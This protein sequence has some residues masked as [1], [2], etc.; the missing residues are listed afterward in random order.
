MNLFL[1]IR[2]RQL[3]QGNKE[4]E[5]KLVPCES[6]KGVS[7]DQDSLFSRECLLDVSTGD[8]G[9][10]VSLLSPDSAVSGHMRASIQQPPLINQEPIG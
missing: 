4:K 5:N 2:G 3:Q 9:F 8:F 6:G 7:V 10:V 1:S